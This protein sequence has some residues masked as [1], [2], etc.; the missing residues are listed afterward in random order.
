M[1]SSWPASVT[2][3]SSAT[4]PTT[5]FETTKK[6]RIN[7]TSTNGSRPKLATSAPIQILIMLLDNRGK[8]AGKA[9]V[10][11]GLFFQ[12]VAGKDHVVLMRL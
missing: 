9:F 3:A 10:C 11:L 5:G 12:H 8:P 4:P 1:S 6:P 2:R 7:Q